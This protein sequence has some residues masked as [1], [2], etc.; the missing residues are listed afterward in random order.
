MTKTLTL[1]E[2]LDCLEQLGDPSAPTIARQLEAIGDLMAGKLAAV[3]N[4]ECG[5]TRREESAFAGTCARFWPKTPGQP[6]PEPL[7]F[8]DATEWD[9]G[10][11]DVD[12]LIAEGER[13]IDQAFYGE[14]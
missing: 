11:D 7:A 3:L 9:D 10:A 2:M 14:R 4:V 6:C 8:Y 1:D 12:R 5:D 13:A